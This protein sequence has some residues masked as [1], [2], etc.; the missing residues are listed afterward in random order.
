MSSNIAFEPP[1][2][3]LSRRATGALRESAPAARSSW[4]L[5]AAQ[6]QRTVERY[7][8]RAAAELRS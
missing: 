1:D 2:C 3:P 8:R 5:A 6:L 4:S 7:R